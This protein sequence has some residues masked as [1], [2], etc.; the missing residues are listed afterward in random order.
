MSEL[1]P[2]KDN[3]SLLRDPITN[4]IINC[5]TSDYENYLILKEKKENEYK[6]IKNIENEI[7]QIKNDLSEIKSLIKS[8]IEI[9]S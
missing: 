1:I 2:I 9:S 5:N 3:T 4:S 6:K 7:G 8:F